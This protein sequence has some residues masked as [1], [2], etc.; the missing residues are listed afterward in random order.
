MPFQEMLEQRCPVKYCSLCNKNRS[1]AR[2]IPSSSAFFMMKNQPF[3][4]R[5]AF[6]LQGI[7]AAICLESSFR[8]QCLAALIV[9]AVLVYSRPAFIWWALLLMNCGMVLAAELFN[10][11]LE[12]LIDHMHPALHP[13]IKIAK[14]CAAGAVLIL[15]ISAVGVFVAFLVE[16]TSTSTK[17]STAQITMSLVAREISVFNSSVADSARRIA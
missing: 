11:A 2:H 1:H 6:A 13:S 8:L 5:M 9:V 14:D 15:S 10:T 7:R 16:T 12:H 3:H 4:K 17:K